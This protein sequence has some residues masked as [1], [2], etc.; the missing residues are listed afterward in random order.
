TG[1]QA[2][3]GNTSVAVFE[4]L[5]TKAPVSALQLSPGLPPELERIINKCLEKDRD[6]RYQSAAELRADLKRLKREMDSGRSAVGVT[7]A[8]PP[9][10]AP[11][12]AKHNTSRWPIALAAILIVIGALTIGFYLRR[13]RSSS[14]QA[15]R[16]LAVLPFTNTSG[17]PKAEYLSD[18]ITESTID[19]LSQLPNLKVM[20]RST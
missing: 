15:I 2:F 12:A 13:G 19:T 14:S 20:A 11:P 7:V 1:K 5:L 17:D 4:S 6:V 9:S 10:V 8:G 18:G 3:S 16:S